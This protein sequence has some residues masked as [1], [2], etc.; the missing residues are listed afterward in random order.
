MPVWGW[1]DEEK[2]KQLSAVSALPKHVLALVYNTY[3]CLHTI[4]YN[5]GRV[6]LHTTRHTLR[7]TLAT[8]TWLFDLPLL[9]CRQLLVSLLPLQLSSHNRLVVRKSLPL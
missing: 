7:T 3:H 9:P 6:A 4:A 1:S 5:P 8:F 2:R